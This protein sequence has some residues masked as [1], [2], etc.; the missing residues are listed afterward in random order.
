MGTSWQGRPDTV[1]PGKGTTIG[2]LKRTVQ[3]AETTT[4]EE[5]VAEGHGLLEVPQNSRRAGINGADATVEAT[6]VPRP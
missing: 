3:V 4:A 1:H 6:A 5:H 2:G